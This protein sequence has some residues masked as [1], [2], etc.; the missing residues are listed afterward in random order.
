MFCKLVFRQPWNWR[1]LAEES[2]PWLLQLKSIRS[3][4]IRETLMDSK[5]TRL[6]DTND[7][8]S[9][10]FYLGSTTKTS[11]KVTLRSH[12]NN[13]QYL[14]VFLRQVIKRTNIEADKNRPGRS[15]FK[16]L[17]ARKLATLS[18]YYQFHSLTLFI[19]SVLV[20]LNSLKFGASLK[21][22]R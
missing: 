13:R 19:Q 6:F 3:T 21:R 9:F 8:L 18:F 2:L 22:G 5:H 17:S 15:L 7:E 20:F 16:V 14:L 11:R 4:A 1:R 12:R 10:G